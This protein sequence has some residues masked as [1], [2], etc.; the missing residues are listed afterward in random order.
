M[1]RSI[2]TGV[3]AA[4][5]VL[6]AA[7]GGWWTRGAPVPGAERPPAP[8]AATA[9]DIAS[10]LQGAFVAVSQQVRP[11]VVNVGVIQSGRRRAAGAPPGADDPTMRDLFKNFFGSDVP[12]SARPEFRQPSLG[13]GVIIDKRGLVLTNHHVVMG[14]DEVTVRLSDKRE[15]RGKI[16]GF[17]KK[18][19]LALLRFDPDHELR[20]AALGDSDRLNV[21]EW[22]IAIGNP[23]ALDQTVTVGVISAT[24][25]SDVGVATYENFIQTDASINPGN[26]GGPLL[27][28]RGEVIGINTAIVASGQGIGFAI[29]INMVKKVV[30]QLASSGKVVRGWIGVN[31]QPLS[32]DLFEALGVAD[33]KGALVTSTAAGSPAATAGLQKEDVILKY[34]GTVVEDY[35][36]LQRLVADTK[37]GAT[38]AVEVLR[39]K[40]PVALKLTIGETP[41]DAPKRDAAP[42]K[43]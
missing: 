9:G 41:D 18:T 7:A 13:S 31:L 11:A 36:H 3:V 5:A 39:K 30:D 34:D 20:V 32:S 29:P 24:G 2:L 12:P 8:A 21:G 17:D 33:R 10:S 19:D 27:N 1:N 28:L 42:K 25:R 37:P 40:K 14:A 4:L 6:A 38:V 15:Y 23:F 43:S 22:A 26:S 35:R 16:M